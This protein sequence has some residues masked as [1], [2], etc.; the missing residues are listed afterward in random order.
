MPPGGRALYEIN[1]NTNQS[2]QVAYNWSGDGQSFVYFDVHAHR[3]PKVEY[4]EKGSFVNRSGSFLS[5]LGGI[6]SLLWKNENRL[7]LPLNVTL[8]GD[9]TVHSV[10]EP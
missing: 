7:A 2:A 9:F 10:H 4:L 6:V 1:I 3:G 5:P 8:S